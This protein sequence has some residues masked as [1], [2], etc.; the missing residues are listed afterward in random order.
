MAVTYHK[1]VL[2]QRQCALRVLQNC[3]WLKCMLPL[4]SLYCSTVLY[5]VVV[6]MFICGGCVLR[7]MDQTFVLM[8]Q[9]SGCQHPAAPTLA[10]HQ[11]QR[12]A[13]RNDVQ[14]VLLRRVIVTITA[15]G[16]STQH[17]TASAQTNQPARSPHISV[18][19]PE[20]L[21]G[22]H[23]SACAASWTTPAP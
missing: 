3:L 22:C 18:H 7:C 1:H 17:Y 15:T 8:Q 23:I 16:S 19:A 6:M 13:S 9:S 5:A 21:E 2:H 20:P 10:R 12:L 4:F 14:L 11:D